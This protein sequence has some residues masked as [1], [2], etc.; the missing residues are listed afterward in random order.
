MKKR[1]M[2]MTKGITILFLVIPLW[3]ADIRAEETQKNNITNIAPQAESTYSATGKRDPFKPFI[4]IIET[5]EVEPQLSKSLPPI[6]RYSL[7]QF[8]L[9]GIISMGQR[10]K[11]MIVD[12]EKN[13][14]VLGIGDEIGNRQ[15]KIIEVRDNGI[16]VEEKRYFEDVFGQKRVEIKKSS[17]AFKEE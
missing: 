6:K 3:F 15:G 8:R 4:K 2:D 7:E 12:P 10:P 13:T 5:K 14:Y 16:L 1:R 17:L 9:V 11:A